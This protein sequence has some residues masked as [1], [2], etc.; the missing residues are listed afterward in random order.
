MTTKE[1]LQQAIKKYAND[2][3]SP[4]KNSSVKFLECENERDFQV[5]FSITQDFNAKGFIVKISKDETKT[6]DVCYDIILQNMIESFIEKH[7]L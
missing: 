5:E 7:T 1:F 4:T 3:T 6:N 2:P